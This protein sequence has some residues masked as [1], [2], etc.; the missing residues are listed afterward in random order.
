MLLKK[1][2]IGL[3]FFGILSCL[4]AQSLVFKD[5]LLNLGTV[6]EGA[7]VNWGFWIKNN[8]SVS[9]SISLRHICGC[10]EFTATNYTIGAGALLYVPV[11]YN[12]SGNKGMVTRG[13]WVDYVEQGR[14]LSQKISFKAT[15]DTFETIGKSGPINKDLCYSFDRTTIDAGVIEHGPPFRFVYKVKNCSSKP[16]I[17]NS[18]RS[19]C[20]CVSPQWSREPV[21]PGK[22]SEIVAN[23]Y[24]MG[25]P[26][27]FTKTL[28]VSFEGV[29]KEVILTLKG[30]VVT[31]SET[32]P[33][34]NNR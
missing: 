32:V 30:E 4:N 9:R 23:Y 3:F 24:T 21:L 29:D 2:L 27:M 22:E 17:I 8:D 11:V 13:L 7:R 5:T 12:S 28:S 10:T 16:L 33:D 20:G 1:G 14:T 19:S 25:R 18:V 26:G 31:H 15:I 34:I 6:S